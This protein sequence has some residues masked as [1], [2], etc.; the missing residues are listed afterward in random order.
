MPDNRPIGF[1]DSGVGG[2]SVVRAARA[3]FP[4]ENFIMFGDSAN[5]PYGDKPEDEV[6]RLTVNAALTLADENIKALV[7]ACNTATSAAL[8]AV[9]G[10]LSVPVI[11]MVPALDAARALRRTGDI[12]MMATTGTVNGAAFRRV[13]SAHGDHVIPL[14]CPGLVDLIEQ[15]DLDSPAMTAR[16]SAILT[17]YRGA[18]IDVVVLGCTHF[19]FIRP[20][21][22]SFFRPDTAFVDGS[23]QVIT[24]LNKLM[25]G[26]SL[27]AASAGTGDTRLKTS[28][29]AATLQ[30]M[31]R[32]LDA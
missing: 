10:A 32:L 14:A 11:G 25:K 20:L 13:L 27:I 9:R 30:L 7:I 19:P 28:G 22:A 8:Q 4:Q 2:L 24:A 23:A 18:P 21:I 3:A 16:L 1:L 31:R 12:L 15:G 26:G 5:A 17:P 29:S 6:R